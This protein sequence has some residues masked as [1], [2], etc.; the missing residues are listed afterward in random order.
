MAPTECNHTAEWN[1]IKVLTDHFKDK[2]EIANNRI[3]ESAEKTYLTLRTA[4]HLNADSTGED[5]SSDGSY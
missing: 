4:T 5:S 3:R 2:I 1:M